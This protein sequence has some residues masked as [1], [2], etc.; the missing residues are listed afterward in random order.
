MDADDLREVD[1][2]IIDKLKEGRNS[3][4]NIA[5][6]VRWG[7]PYVAER[8]RRLTDEGILTNIGRG[9]YE[10]TPEEVP[11]RDE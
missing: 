3:A 4:P 6:E 5:D 2:S 7:K 9:I 11:E 10:L 1:W 8:C